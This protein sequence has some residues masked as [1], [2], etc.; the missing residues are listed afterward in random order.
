MRELQ[1]VLADNT[2][3]GPRYGAVGPG[4]AAGGVAETV[5]TE[6]QPTLAEVRKDLERAMVRDVLGHRNVARTTGK[7]GVT[8]PREADDPAPDRPVQSGL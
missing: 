2:V 8:R 6:R 3:T 4:R 5:G 7:M 1:D